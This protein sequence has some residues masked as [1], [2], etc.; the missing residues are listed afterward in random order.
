MGILGVEGSFV[1]RRT[2]ENLLHI[3][4]FQRSS[5]CRKTPK[6]IFKLRGSSGPSVG[7]LCIAH[8]QRVFCGYFGYKGKYCV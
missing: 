3:K 2:P 6:G 4:Y 5:I 1:F 7:L 8:P